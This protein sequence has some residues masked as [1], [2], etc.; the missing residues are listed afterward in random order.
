MGRS[1]KMKTIGR[2]LISMALA[3]IILAFILGASSS[4]LAVWFIW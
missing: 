4:L 1:K 3:M 2:V